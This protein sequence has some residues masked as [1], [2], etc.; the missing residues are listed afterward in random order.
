MPARDSLVKV[1]PSCGAAAANFFGSTPRM[2]ASH[3]YGASDPPA[4]VDSA[5]ATQARHSLLAILTTLIIFNH[6]LRRINQLI[7]GP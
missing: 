6:N 1:G 7:F 5:P 3:G 2:N 4:F